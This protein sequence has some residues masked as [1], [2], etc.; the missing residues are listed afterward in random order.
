MSPWTKAT[1]T[2]YSILFHVGSKRHL[3]WSNT[4]RVHQTKQERFG[5]RFAVARIF[6]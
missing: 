1:V 3:G 6:D 4:S 2:V 5:A